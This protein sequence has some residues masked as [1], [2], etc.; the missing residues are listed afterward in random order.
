M[1]APILGLLTIGLAASAASA[2]VR[3]VPSALYP[4]I[5]SAEN[6]ALPGDTINIAAGTYTENVLIDVNNLFVQ[7]SCYNPA[8]VVVDGTVN[9]VFEVV[10]NNVTI[11]CL[12]TRNGYAGVYADPGTGIQLQ[13]L[14]ILSASDFGIYIEAGNNFR[15]QAVEI[16]GA[17]G[18]GIYV[19]QGDNGLIQSTTVRNVA[20]H[21]IN[22]DDSDHVTVTGNTL[23]Q[24]GSYTDPN[25]FYE[26]FG[27]GISGNDATVSNNSISNTFFSGIYVTG[28]RTIVWK[29]TLKNAA[30]TDDS[31]ACAGD[32]VVVDD[33]VSTNCYYDCLD[34]EGARAKV[35]RNRVESI[36]DYCVDAAGDDL[37]LTDNVCTSSYYGYYVYYGDRARI[38]RNVAER[39]LFG[40]FEIYGDDLKVLNNRATDAGGYDAYYV[41]CADCDAT[42][43]RGNEA[44]RQGSYYYDYGGFYLDFDSPGAAVS[45]NRSIDGAGYGYYLD[46]DSCVMTNNLAIGNGRT[47][48][49]GFI[50]NGNSNTLSFNQSQ[51]NQGP[52]YRV[53]GDL[54]VF[55]QN[56]ALKNL[57]EGFWIAS[58]TDNRLSQNT[59][60]AN[61]AEGIDN[62]GTLTDLL[63]NVS[64]GNRRDCTNDVT[65]D[66][67]VGNTCADGSNFNETS[68]V[69]N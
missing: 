24:C 8:Y 40:A 18:H 25:Y 19:A 48:E 9:T 27:I 29:N 46:A 41:N 68:Q 32:D 14:R 45:G 13:N 66:Q 69:D 7:G 50:I 67:R 52:G 21:C 33:N 30:W 42:E 36:D 15:I 20:R 35:R 37:L 23:L 16:R 43:V 39:V 31:I 56:S 12:T 26:G 17:E 5:Q 65:F 28:D 54:N 63:S 11:K 6:A 53:D 64:L 1:R 58:G 38:E 10:S 44:V 59:V 61:A 51:E 2:V 57:Q 55:T 62:D 34:V 4:T 47:P 3:N 60:N 49:A 22:L